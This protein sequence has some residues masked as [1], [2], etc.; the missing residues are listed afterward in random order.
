MEGKEWWI[1]T[2]LPIKAKTIFDSK[3]LVNLTIIAPF[4]LIAEIVLML[5]LKPNLLDMIWLWVLPAIFMLF[6]CV[7]GITIN[8]IFPVFNWE[9]EVTVVKQSVAAMIGGIG[10][11]FIII[12][13]SLPVIFITQISSD[14]IKLIIAIAVTGVTVWLYQKNAQVNL[15][16]IGE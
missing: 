6:S 15:Q 13:C 4:Y 16:E 8:L 12:I 9:N 1:V 11:F 3:I 14:W 2:S 7:Y 5:A 10:G